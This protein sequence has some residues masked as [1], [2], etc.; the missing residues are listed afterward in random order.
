M[1]SGY[2]ISFIR[3]PARGTSQLY[4][5]V[6]RTSAFKQF[7]LIITIFLGTG[8]NV[9]LGEGWVEVGVGLDYLRRYNLGR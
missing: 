8:S 7:F 3:D 4:L 6:A 9:A 2:S 1:T 5:R